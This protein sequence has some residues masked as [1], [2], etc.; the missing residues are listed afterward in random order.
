VFAFTYSPAEGL[1]AVS[2]GGS[3]VN[4]YVKLAGDGTDTWDPGF[5]VYGDARVL[6]A[7]SIGAGTGTGLFEASGV[8]AATGDLGL[9]DDG[10]VDGMH[11]IDSADMGRNPMMNGKG[12]GCGIVPATGAAAWSV[13]VFAL[14]LRL[15]FRRRAAPARPRA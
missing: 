4:V 9:D 15:L 8:M 6:Y 2:S 11:P 14:F 12:C 5:G 10:G 1:L 7:G 13:A 3:D